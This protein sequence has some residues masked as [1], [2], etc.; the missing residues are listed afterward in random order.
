MLGDMTRSVFSP[1]YRRL[2]QLL[3]EA[4][5]RKGLTQ[6]ELGSTLRRYQVFVSRYERGERRLDITELLEIA[7]ALDIDPHFIVAYVQSIRRADGGLN[8]ESFWALAKPYELMKVL[9]QDPELRELI[10]SRIAELK[11]DKT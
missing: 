1:E 7:E 3:I 4:R 11:P 2:L 9:E 8:Q 10:L 6:A 5:E